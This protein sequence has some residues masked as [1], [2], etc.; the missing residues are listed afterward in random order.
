MT[1]PVI[2]PHK[3]KRKTI[4]SASMTTR[5]SR[6]LTRS[7]FPLFWSNVDKIQVSAEDRKFLFRKELRSML[8]GFGDDKM[9]YDKTLETLEA[10]VV[11]YIKVF[12]LLFLQKN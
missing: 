7:V 4:S 9:P 2:R 1:I 3:W 11:D 12:C 10:I 5:I 8:Y 6:S